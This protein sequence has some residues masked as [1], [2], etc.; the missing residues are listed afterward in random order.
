MEKGLPEKKNLFLKILILLQ[1]CKNKAYLKFHTRGDVA[2]GKEDPLDAEMINAPLG[3][4]F[5]SSTDC[6]YRILLTKYLSI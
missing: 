5:A 6:S 3:I 4:L 1:V 2:L